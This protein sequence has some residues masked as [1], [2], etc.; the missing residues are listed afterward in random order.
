LSELG[1]SLW[2]SAREEVT[3]VETAAEL[4]RDFSI[5]KVGNILAIHE[6]RMDQVRERLLPIGVELAVKPV[7]PTES[8]AADNSVKAMKPKTRR[9]R[10]KE[11]AL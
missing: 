4:D 2:S 5:G 9:S 3:Q 6:D 7:A 11:P 1:Y 8:R 10:V